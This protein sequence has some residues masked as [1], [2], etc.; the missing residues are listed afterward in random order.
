MNLL[1]LF[2]SQNFS[3]KI[4]VTKLKSQNFSHKIIF[5]TFVVTTITTVTTVTT[6]TTVTTVTTVANVTTVTTVSQVGFNYLLIRVTFSQTSGTDQRTDR[7]TDR[8]T[9][10]PTD[11]QLEKGLG[12]SPKQKKETFKKYLVPL[13][14][15]CFVICICLTDPV[16]P[17]LFYHHLCN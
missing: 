4:L 16:Q 2:Q 17:G 3:H 10:G 8:W 5:T 1:T 14:I 9:D 11:R 12:F 6:F 13:N 15:S 7:P